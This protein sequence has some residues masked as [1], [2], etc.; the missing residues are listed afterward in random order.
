MKNDNSIIFTS[1]NLLDNIDKLGPWS[2][3]GLA[4]IAL[5]HYFPE[6]YDEDGNCDVSIEVELCA[7]L[8]CEYWNDV[9]IKYQTE[10][11]YDAPDG[12]NPDYVN[13]F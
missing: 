9:I 13:E 10:V 7:K 8:G 3:Y 11:G 12:F 6:Y 2:S 4:R 5:K 1:D